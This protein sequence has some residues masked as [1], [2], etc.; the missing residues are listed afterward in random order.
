MPC[1][2][3]CPREAV[4]GIRKAL[5]SQI[6]MAQAAYTGAMALS[7][8]VTPLKRQT[9]SADVYQQLRELLVSGK[10]MPGEQLSLRSIAEALG[11]SVMPVRE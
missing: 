8:L 10:V 3:H 9:L 5:C 11:V 7:A 4:P 1:R 6:T 2:R